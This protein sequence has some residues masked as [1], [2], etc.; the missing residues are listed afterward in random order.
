[1][2][3]Q[4]KNNCP[5]IIWH[6]RLTPNGVRYFIHNLLHFHVIRLIQFFIEY[7]QF[8][9]ALNPSVS[10]GIWPCLEDKLPETSFDKYYF[11]Q[12]V[13]G[14]KMCSQI[15]PKMIVDIGSTA[16]LV[17]IFSQF[18]ETVSLD[19]RPLPVRING[20]LCKKGSI[21]QIP[22]ADN[23][24]QYIN[25]LCVLEHIGL[26]RY[27][28]SIDTKGIDKAI[29][30]LKRVLSPGGYLA[31]SVPI[32][33]PCILFNALRIFSRNELIG[34]FSSYTIIDETFCIPEYSKNDPTPQLHKGEYQIYCVCM[35]K[36]S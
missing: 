18:A 23:S 12:D 32:G 13:W 21:T 31:L 28:D 19:I 36:T 11:Y 10:L 1:M 5:S 4:L 7:F 35:Q 17:G 30:E 29:A 14:A 16:L 9:K 27:G 26:G 6:T 33:I 2:I 24:I 34:F 3:R 22:Y 8:K 25:S 20:L 15:K